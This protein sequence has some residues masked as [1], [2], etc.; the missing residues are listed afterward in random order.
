ML[1]REVLAT[2]KVALGAN[3]PDPDLEGLCAGDPG[4]AVTG[5]AVSFAPSVE[6]LRR[7][8]EGGCNVVLADAHPFFHYDAYWSRL[9]GVFATVEASEAVAAKRALIEQ[10]GLAV[11]RLRTAWNAANPGAAAAALARALRL[12]PRGDAEQPYV[13]CD[14][15]GRLAGEL[16]SDV[17]TILKASALRV[18]GSPRTRVRRV[19]VAP[20]LV[21]TERLGEILQDPTIDVV[22]GG[23]VIEWHAGPYMQDVIASGRRA[24]LILTGFAASLEPGAAALHAF[25]QAQL[26]GVRV[27]HLP[28]REPIWAPVRG[29][30][31]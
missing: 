15:S 30:A 29:V 20:G 3:G 28:G 2:L 13:T 25:A 1:V 9:P 4:T 14:V 21:T 26:A 23:E 11:L 27:I 8:R 7:A 5:V 12:S 17:E 24:T 19:A 31:A 6:V 18:V 10:G 16:I 22:I